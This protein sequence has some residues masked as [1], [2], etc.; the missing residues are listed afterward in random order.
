VANGW[1]KNVNTG[2]HVPHVHDMAGRVTLLF[3]ATED[4]EASLED[5]RQASTEKAAP[6]SPAAH[7]DRQLPAASADHCEFRWAGLRAVPVGGWPAHRVR[8]Q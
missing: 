4:L 1:I 7:A 3:K 5:R 2:E 8:Q 6:P